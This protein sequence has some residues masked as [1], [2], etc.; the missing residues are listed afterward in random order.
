MFLKSIVLCVIVFFS[1]SEVKATQVVPPAYTNTPGTTA[2]IGPH[3]N[4][5]RTNQLLIHSS[6]LSSLVGKRLTAISWRSLASATNTWPASDVTYTSYNIFLSGSVDPADRSFT[7]ANNIV[8]P[9]TQVRSGVLF[10][11]AGSYTFG[12]SP[13]A[14][15]P[16]IEFNTPYLYTGGNLLI[17]LRTSAFSGISRSVDAIGTAVSG[18]GTNFSACW[19]SSDTGT[20]GASQGNFSIVRISTAPLVLDLTCLIEARYN[21]GSNLMISD[22]TQVYLQSAISPFNRVDSATAVLDINGKGRFRFFNASSGDDYFVVVNHRNS[23][24]TWSA[25]AEDFA[26]DTV[27]YDFTV[28]ASA[29]FGSNQELVGSRWTN[30]SG[31]V[32]KDGVIDLTDLTIVANDASAFVNGY[33]L[34]DVNGDLITDL[35]DQLIVYDNSSQFIEV[36][37]P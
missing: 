19:K 37:S 36:V 22:T 3:A 29:A 12:S 32:N 27:I 31:D 18:Y 34:S 16:E 15:G 26:S 4:T 17:E 6:Q 14:F 10:I 8:G 25:A 1:L 23:I 24:E 20:V 2:F 9:Q 13:N 35:T 33:V 7:F 11:P 5:A 21:S 28:A 30:Y